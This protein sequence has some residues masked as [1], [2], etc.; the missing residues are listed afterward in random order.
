MIMHSRNV[1][2]FQTRKLRGLKNLVIQFNF[3]LRNYSMKPIAAFHQSNR[4][5][6]LKHVYMA[7]AIMGLMLCFSSMAIGGPSS[8][9]QPPISIMDLD[10]D[11]LL[12]DDELF[13]GTDPNNPDTDE[14]GI[15]DGVDP[16]VLSTIIESLDDDAFK[17]KDRGHRTALVALL[18][19]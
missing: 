8:G 10:D 19:N 5:Y 9:P 1:F 4:H 18:S 17:S 14:D 2:L 13:A 12:N 3:I 7:I 6:F 11:G 16:D 15:P